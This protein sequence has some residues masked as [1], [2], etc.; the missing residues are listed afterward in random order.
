MRVRRVPKRLESAIKKL[1]TVPL[2][3]CPQC[4]G[5]RGVLRAYRATR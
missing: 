3:K 2:C 4:K 1:M 5:I